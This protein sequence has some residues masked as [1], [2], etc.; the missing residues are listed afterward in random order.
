MV[1]A[2]L[3][4]FLL[5]GVTVGVHA[6]GTALWLRFLRRRRGEMAGPL[7]PWRAL[8]LL[9]LTALFLLALQMV[10]VVLWAVTYLMIPQVGDLKTFEQ[11]V[12]FSTV[13]FTTLGYGDLTLT[14]H[15]RLLS[16]MEAM[17]GIL[18]IGWSTALLFAVV[19]RLLPQSAEVAPHDED[20]RA[21]VK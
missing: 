2:L 7:R 6:V 4:G 13:T 8:K 3:V 20:K 17:N 5:M 16:G 1:K 11:A 12:Y 15:W 14:G 19:Q 21:S 10:E 18:L 9:G